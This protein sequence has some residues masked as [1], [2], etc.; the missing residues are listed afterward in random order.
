MNLH[1]LAAIHEAQCSSAV[2]L[3]QIDVA[4]P[5]HP[6]GNGRGASLDIVGEQLTDHGHGVEQTLLERQD[7]SSKTPAVMQRFAKGEW[8]TNELTLFNDPTMTANNFSQCTWGQWS[9]RHSER[10]RNNSS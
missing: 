8:R 10:K 9:I 3:S 4:L 6:H 2:Q 5:Q 7:M 1:D